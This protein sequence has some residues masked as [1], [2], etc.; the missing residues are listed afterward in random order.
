MTW[1]TGND[2]K[3]AQSL[4]NKMGGKLS[5]WLHFEIS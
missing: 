3:A 4:Y 2:N 1:E 5:Q